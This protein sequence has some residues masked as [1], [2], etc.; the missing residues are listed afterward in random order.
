MTP[1]ALTAQLKQE[2][3]VDEADEEESSRHI[4]CNANEPLLTSCGGA[5]RQRELGGLTLHHELGLL[6]LAYHLDYP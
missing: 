5:I 6:Q 1:D 4:L 2:Q 3:A